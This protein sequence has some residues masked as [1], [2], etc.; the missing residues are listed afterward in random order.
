MEF[1]E[2]DYTLHDSIKETF[3]RI[4]QLIICQKPSLLKHD[5]NYI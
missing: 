5:E 3:I 4:S 2:G 1:V